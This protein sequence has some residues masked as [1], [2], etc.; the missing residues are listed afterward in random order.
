[1]NSFYQKLWTFTINSNT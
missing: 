1:M